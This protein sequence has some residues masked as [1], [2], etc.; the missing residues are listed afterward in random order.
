MNG[1]EDGRLIASA[2]PITS[3]SVGS[4][5]GAGGLGGER[6]GYCKTVKLQRGKTAG[7]GN[8]HRFQTKNLLKYWRK[9]KKRRK[10]GKIGR[11]H[12]WVMSRKIPVKD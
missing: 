10:R 11:K 9:R 2:E 5:G 7:G 6:G 12:P 1:L 3:M 4:L 8:R